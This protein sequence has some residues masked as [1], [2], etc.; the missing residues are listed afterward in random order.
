MIQEKATPRPWKI[1]K[2][3]NYIGAC[4]VSEDHRITGTIIDFF[5]SKEATGNAELIVRSVNAHDALVE[6]C[7]G[8]RDSLN[9][10]PYKGRAID[11][12]DRKRILTDALKQAGEA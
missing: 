10:Y 7:R 9:G 11:D 4:I 2:A 8:V 3:D 6:A 12:T 5:E 1:K